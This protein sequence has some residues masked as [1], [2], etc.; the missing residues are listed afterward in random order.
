MRS[1]S[2]KGEG[3]WETTTLIGRRWKRASVELT[4]TNTPGNLSYTTHAFGT[5]S[6]SL[7]SFRF[8][9]IA[10]SSGSASRR[11][12]EFLAPIAAGFHPFPSRT[13]QLSPPAPMVVGPQGPSRVGR[14]QINERKARQTASLSVL[15]FLEVSMLRSVSGLC[16]AAIFLFGANGIALGSPRVPRSL[17]PSSSTTTE[18]SKIRWRC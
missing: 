16:L 8:R 6:S 10:W 12:S 15:I 18:S 9:D 2:R 7:C 14:R 3:S 5:G 1:Q 11:G 4:G 17:V 13:R